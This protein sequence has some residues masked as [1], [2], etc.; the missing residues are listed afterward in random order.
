MATTKKTPAKK[1]AAAK[2][3][4]AKSPKAKT[5]ASVKPTTVNP[6]AKATPKAPAKK[7][8]AKTPA[9]PAPAKKPAAKAPAKGTPAKKPAPK[10]A[11]AK[12][13][14]AKVAPAKKP[15]AAKPTAKPAPAKKSAAKPVAKASAKATPAK[16]PAPK[17]A[18]A[19]KPAPT[20]KAPVAKPAAKAPVAKPEGKKAAA[21]TKAPEA[22]VKPTTAL[23]TN[24]P[25][26][27]VRLAPVGPRFPVVRPQSALR[28]GSAKGSAAAVVADG[29]TPFSDEELEKYAE[30]LNKER[31]ELLLRLKTLQNEALTHGG[32]EN[33]EEDGTGAFTQSHYLRVAAEANAR[34]AA[35]NQALQAIKDKKYGV[36]QMCG[37]KISRDRLR[38][39][40]ASI[41]CVSCKK[42]YEDGLRDTQA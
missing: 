42:K 40:L 6:V 29:K 17:A 14:V 3:A 41:R 35:I 27:G 31:D 39:N 37:C 19:K 18:P 21:T 23:P 26:P 13:S 36:C 12:K 8:A 32:E 7:S 4:P 9:K 22:T 30:R 34:I 1:P 24:A 15:A 25:A 16:K 38:A 28:G 10:A 33:V 2:A 5:K 20:K 11:P